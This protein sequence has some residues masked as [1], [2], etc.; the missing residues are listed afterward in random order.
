MVSTNVGVFSLVEKRMYIF[1][2]TFE[3]PRLILYGI[4]TGD[5]V[6]SFG[7]HRYKRRLFDL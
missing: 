6:L 1:F 7:I 3:N 2:N 4:R 5:N